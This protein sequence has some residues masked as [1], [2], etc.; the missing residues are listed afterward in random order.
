MKK[1]LKIFLFIIAALALANAILMIRVSNFNIG[2]VLQV[3]VA[4]I[5][6]YCSLRYDK[7]KK[8]LRTAIGIVLLAPFVFMAAISVYGSIDNADYTENAVIVLGNG[9]HGEKIGENLATRLNKAVSYHSQNPDAII[10]V[11]GGQGPQEDIPEALAMARYLLAKGI[12]E[13]SIKMEDQS[14]S[15][16]ENM[17]FAKTIL[18]DCLPPGYSSV[19]VTNDYHVYRAVKTAATA[20]IAANHMATATEWYIIPAIYLRETLAI[21]KMWLTPPPAPPTNANPKA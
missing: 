10:V 1:F 9:I 16:Y 18:D 20:G 6:F 8:S 7:M 4:A 14:T 21:A 12:P 11:C 19:I 5:L 13:T 15:T 3:L 17:A 2:L